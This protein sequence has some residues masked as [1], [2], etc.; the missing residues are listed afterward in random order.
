[1]C[2]CDISVLTCGEPL[3]LAIVPR[4]RGGGA[5]EPDKPEGWKTTYRDIKL[6]RCFTLLNSTSLDEP[7]RIVNQHINRG[8]P[9]QRHELHVTHGLSAPSRHHLHYSTVIMALTYI[10]KPDRE[11]LSLFKIVYLF[12]YVIIMRLLSWL[13]SVLLNRSCKLVWF[14]VSSFCN[15]RF[16]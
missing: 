7:N 13:L 1:M 10:L 12:C 16:S 8:C 5:D 6:K 2:M 11:S 15:Q 9:C 14:V 3:L 4:I